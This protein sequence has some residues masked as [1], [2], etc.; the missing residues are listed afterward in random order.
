MIGAKR[1]LGIVRALNGLFPI[2]GHSSGRRP[3][4]ACAPG[5]RAA[6]KSAFADWLLSGVPSKWEN[7]I[8][9]GRIVMGGK[10]YRAM[11]YEVKRPSF[12][13]VIVELLLNIIG[14]FG[15]GWLMTGHRMVGI[16]LLIFSLAWI[17][18]AT[19][20]TIATFGLGL[21]CLGPMNLVLLLLSTLLLLASVRGAR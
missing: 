7:S 6:A 2:A 19:I 9:R 17:T 14:I 3:A 16:L 13:P 12:A 4:N 10:D 21:L 20:V 1:M 18:T 5:W 11:S 8:M 15:V